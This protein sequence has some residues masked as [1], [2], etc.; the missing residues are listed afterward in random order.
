MSVISGN[1][2]QIL[3]LRVRHLVVC[4]NLIFCL[5]PVK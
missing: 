1:L 5:Y 4:H 3:T 2:K